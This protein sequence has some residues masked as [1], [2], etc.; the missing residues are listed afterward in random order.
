MPKQLPVVPGTNKLGIEIVGL[1]P[2]KDDNGNHVQEAKYVDFQYVNVIYNETTTTAP[3][4]QIR[5]QG[6]KN[7]S[8][9]PGAAFGTADNPTN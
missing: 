3:A 7:N 2:A 4:Q 9:L 1:R 5:A 8:N 6:T